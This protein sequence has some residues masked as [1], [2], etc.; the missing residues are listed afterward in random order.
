VVMNGGKPDAVMIGIKQ[1]G[2]LSL[3]MQA[4]C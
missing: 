4:G 2:G 3:L 1:L